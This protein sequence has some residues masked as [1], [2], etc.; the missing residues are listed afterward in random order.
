MASATCEKQ[1]STEAKRGVLTFLSCLLTTSSKPLFLPSFQAYHDNIL[2][3]FDRKAAT[4]TIITDSF[5]LCL[6]DI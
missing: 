5:G 4:Q 3:Q 6:T 2:P 1:K